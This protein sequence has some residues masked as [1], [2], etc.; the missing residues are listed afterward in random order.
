MESPL[1]FPSG[2]GLM[3]LLTAMD[4]WRSGEA[5]PDDQAAIPL[6]EAPPD[7]EVEVQVAPGEAPHIDEAVVQVAPG[8][9]PPDGFQTPKKSSINSTSV[10][11]VCPS[12][13]APFSFGFLMLEAA[14]FDMINHVFLSL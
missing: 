1:F 11:N 2:S 10:S 13:Y 6:G 14:H 9:A 8:E 7:D 5:P 12:C 3:A 4:A